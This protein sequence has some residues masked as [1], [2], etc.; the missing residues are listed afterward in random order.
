ME[1]RHKDI[2][3]KERFFA[4]FAIF[5]AFGLLIFSLSSCYVPSPL[6][7]KW[8][9]N[10]GNLIHFQSDASFSARIKT[11]SGSTD[12]QGTY[13]VNE[14][15]LVFDVEMPSFRV[16]SEW[17]VRGSMLYLVWKDSSGESVS[18][19]LYLISNK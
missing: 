18:L 14:N 16:V 15:V 8:T 5:A 12:Y 7:G 2:K 3:M 17:D 1:N 13:V 9:D 10:A 19:T 6:Y 4:R 11:T